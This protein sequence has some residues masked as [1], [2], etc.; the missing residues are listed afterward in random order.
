MKLFV[1][2]TNKGK[3]REILALFLDSGIK[4]VFPQD[5][6]ETAELEVDET[7][8]TFAENALLKAQAFGDITGLLTVADDS[9]L[10]VTA[11]DGFPGV[12]SNRWFP[13]TDTERNQ[14]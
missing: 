1:A 10:Q 13:G 3:Q 7:G 5:F 4:L 6:P 2:T 8:E 12:K 14:A 9:G 11:L